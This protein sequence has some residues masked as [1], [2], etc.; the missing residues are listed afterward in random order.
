MRKQVEWLSVEENSTL[1]A[2]L[3]E[4]IQPNGD[5]RLQATPG[6]E[7]PVIT[8]RRTFP[9]SKAGCRKN[10]TNRKD[11]LWMEGRVGQREMTSATSLAV[12]LMGFQTHSI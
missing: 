12:T 9:A 5:I 6:N 2:T 10:L 7:P 3:I 8:N 11:S 1:T 4:Q